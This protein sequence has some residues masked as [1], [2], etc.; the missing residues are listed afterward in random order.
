MTREEAEAVCYYMA[1]E[2]DSWTDAL[3]N[4]KENLDDDFQGDEDEDDSKEV[5]S[6]EDQHLHRVADDRNSTQK[7]PESRWS[8]PIHRRIVREEALALGQTKG[9]KS[10]DISRRGWADSSPHMS[11]GLPQSALESDQDINVENDQASTIGSDESSSSGSGR[12]SRSSTEECQGP[13]GGTEDDKGF[14][15]LNLG[16]CLYAWA[17]QFQSEVFDHLLEALENPDTKF[18]LPEEGDWIEQKLE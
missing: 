14:N 18:K 13:M 15:G 3:Q 17:E 16:R 6:F 11:M 4:F 9:G 12:R 5:E 10:Q 7:R 1:K 2:R 8:Q